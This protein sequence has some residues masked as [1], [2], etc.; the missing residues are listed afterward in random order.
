MPFHGGFQEASSAGGSVRARHGAGDPDALRGA[1]VPG[2]YMEAAGDGGPRRD[3]LSTCIEARRGARSE[4][5]G[6]QGFKRKP[7]LSDWGQPFKSVQ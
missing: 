2:K 1:T 6:V 5:P 7:G 3:F 4:G